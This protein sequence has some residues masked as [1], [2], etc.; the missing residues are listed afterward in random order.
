MS[1]SELLGGDGGRKVVHGREGMEGFG[2]RQLF[3]PL[4][5]CHPENISPPEI[6]P[7]FGPPVR[8]EQ[9]LMNALGGI[10]NL[11]NKRN[12]IARKNWRKVGVDPV[13]WY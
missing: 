7:S 10:D 12:A 9:E 4:I 3:D 13:N 5:P 11:A 6:H 8:A 1:S 2:C